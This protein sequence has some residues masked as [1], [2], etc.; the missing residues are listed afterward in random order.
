MRVFN[1]VLT[2]LFAILLIS[3]NKPVNWHASD[4]SGM[5]PDLEFTLTG[6][7]GNAFN[8]SS[9]QGK[10]ALIFFGFTSC[11]DV[12]PTT[13]TQ[14]S[15]VMKNLGTRANDIQVVLVS[16]DPDR[17]TPEVMR[18]YTASFGPWLLGL[19]GAEQPLTQLRETYGVY[20][21]MESSDNKGTYNVMHSAAIFVFDAK[22]RARL[23][24]SD[25][26]DTDAVVSDLKQ[27]I[28]Q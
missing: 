8:A 7:D 9:L 5:M 26:H 22:G 27:L 23:L 17:D 28:D 14:L 21:A 13:L 2:L 24:I 4:I 18:T 11:P 6:P 16:V 15:V 12:C 1:L 19:T 10:P 25:V 3:C 20:A